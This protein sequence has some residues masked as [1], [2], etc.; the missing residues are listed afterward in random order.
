LRQRFGRARAIR[1]TDRQHAG[2]A[3][4]FE[5]RVDDA[6]IGKIEQVTQIEHDRGARKQLWCGTNAAFEFLAQGRRIGP[7]YAH[8]GDTDLAKA[9]VASVRSLLIHFYIHERR[10]PARRRLECCQF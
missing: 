9:Q 5:Q 6:V 4:G 3:H 7:S 8:T 10:S 2:T 1:Q